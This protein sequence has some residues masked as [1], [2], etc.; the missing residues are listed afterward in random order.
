MPS[1]FYV[2]WLSHSIKALELG[3]DQAEQ[4]VSN[5]SLMNWFYLGK[6]RKFMPSL[7][8]GL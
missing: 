5:E 4:G 8:V 1:P 3:D 6:G 2:G 7:N